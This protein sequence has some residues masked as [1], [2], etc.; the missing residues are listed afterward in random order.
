VSSNEADRNTTYATL[1]NRL[2]KACAGHPAVAMMDIFNEPL[3]PESDI[4]SFN[5][6]PSQPVAITRAGRTDEDIVDDFVDPL[7]AAIAT[8]DPK[9]KVTSGV[10]LFKST[11][12]PLVFSFA[13]QEYAHTKGTIVT[14]HLYIVDEGHGVVNSVRDP[15]EALDIL[16]TWA[17]TEKPVVWEESGSA[18]QSPL[19][20]ATM[21]QTWMD[22]RSFCAGQLGQWS[23][24]TQEDMLEPG[25]EDTNPGHIFN[26]LNLP[27]FLL[28]LSTMGGE[29]EEFTLDGLPL[30]DGGYQILE[31]A[32]DPPQKRYQ[33]TQS[34]DGTRL[35]DIPG[36]EDRTITMKLRVLAG[37][38]PDEAQSMDRAFD[39]IAAIRQK[40]EEADRLV[41]EGERGV[42]AVYRPSG[43][44]RPMKVYVTGGDIQ[45][46][47]KVVTGDEAGYFASTREPVFMLS[48]TCN[49][50]LYGETVTVVGSSA[51]GPLASL[52]LSDVLGDVPADAEFTLRE[53]SAQD[54]RFVEWGM[55]Q[56]NYNLT[57]LV[58]DSDGVTTTGFSGTGT[59]RSG[60]YDPG[61]AGNSVVRVTPTSSPLAVCGMTDQGHMGR[62]RVRAR[63]FATGSQAA[64]I[65]VRLRWR[66]QQGPWTE[67][68]WVDIPIYG[69][70]CE[71]ELASVVLPR[72]DV[73]SWDWVLDAVGVGGGTDTLDFDCMGL[74]PVDE[75]YGKAS[76]PAPSFVTSDLVAN[77]NFNSLTP[78]T[79][80]NGRTA[81]TGGTWATSASG[82]S[83]ADFVGTATQ[84]A[85]SKAGN[86]EGPNI[87]RALLPTSRTTVESSALFWGQR[88]VDLGTGIN[89]IASLDTGR[90]AV[91]A[92]F[93]DNSNY[94]MLASGSGDPGVW[95]IAKVAGVQTYYA[96]LCRDPVVPAFTWVR[97]RLIV[98]DTGGVY[99]GV[100]QV[101]ISA[102]GVESPGAILGQ[103]L[104]FIPDCATGG[105]LASGTCGFEAYN[106]DNDD[107]VTIVDNYYAS[108]TPQAE[109][110]IIG[111]GSRVR[112][113]SQNAAPAERE[114]NPGQWP[115]VPYR[116]SRFWLPPALDGYSTRLA[117]R[118]R[119]RDLDESDADNITDSVEY[120]VT[121]TP[122]YV[123][124]PQV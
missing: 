46:V 39:H 86:S 1:W 5:V 113:G 14:D 121:Y 15:S 124:V 73:P 26:A 75:G 29:F 2:A 22:A 31:L 38:Q 68:T 63:L 114:L 101:S 83:P 98:Y 85:V 56:R 32:L 105:A 97:F 20:Y 116:G 122:R 89:G 106:W 45:S 66:V 103:V 112:F 119:R 117:W 92:R 120:Q 4:P 72:A 9:P 44:V 118:A 27:P 60:A 10:W 110:P 65:K 123:D 50:F 25:V 33:R 54:R 49:P 13:V 28:F 90:R 6:G 78:A 74:L 37:N 111:A 53:A 11:A 19:S 109:A 34:R 107:N 99:A 70:W 18:G 67:G 64:A 91:I 3:L 93:V 88:W 41:T 62:F 96:G 61:A 17:M 69:I 30:H 57:S 52:T 36:R 76:A 21:T 47:P 71:P 58:L 23:G 12:G 51:Q 82:G 42:V 24:A 7:L 80:L 43:S 94:V 108:T 102:A 81:P 48:L 95:L 115:R 84:G 87:R 8:W 35:A 16:R 77:D 55:Q 40:L 104:T 100:Q 59:T 79:S